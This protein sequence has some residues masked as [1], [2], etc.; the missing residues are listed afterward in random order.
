MTTDQIK[1]VKAQSP[2]LFAKKKAAGLSDAVAAEAIVRQMAY[3]EANPPHVGATLKA[4]EAIAAAHTIQSHANAVREGAEKLRVAALALDP[5][6]E[7]PA[8]PLVGDA[9]MAVKVEELEQQ[10]WA[11]NHLIVE[12][13]DLRRA[14]ESDLALTSADLSA[15]HEQLKAA[16]ACSSIKE[17]RNLLGAAE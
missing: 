1:A 12:L 4:R 8:L 16:A 14:N 9:E 13:T 2:E 7:L 11:A 10:L 5:T 3:D 17:V 15:V 6:A